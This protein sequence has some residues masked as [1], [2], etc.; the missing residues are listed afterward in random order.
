MKT[1]TKLHTKPFEIHS[2]ATENRA[3]RKVATIE[4]QVRVDEDG[5]EV[6]TPESLNLIDKTQARYMGLLMGEDIRAL[7]ERLN[8]S[9]DELSDLLGCGKKSLSR[10]ENGHGYP[11]QLVNTLLRALDERLFTPAQL[12]G[13]QSPRA[14]WG[15]LISGTTPR[16]HRFQFTCTAASAW[17][18]CPATKRG[19]LNFPSLFGS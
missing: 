11:S 13:L 19:E 4:V 7:R 18:D 16:S 5:D 8:L 10:W 3:A 1:T 9:Q 14:D 15:E 2:P 6:L 12:R 17:D